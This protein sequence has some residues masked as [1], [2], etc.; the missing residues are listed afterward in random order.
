MTL[1]IFKQ[2]CRAIKTLVNASIL[3]IYFPSVSHP[4]HQDQHPVVVDFVED[5]VI[6]HPDP[7]AVVAAGKLLDPRRA[8]LIGQGVDFL[9]H[10][11]MHRGFQVAQVADGRRQQFDLVGQATSGPGRP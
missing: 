4:R 2:Y 5:A 1:N 10:A 9:R 8:G 7:V 3:S 6:A 11:L